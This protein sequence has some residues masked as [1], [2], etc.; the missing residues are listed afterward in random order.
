MR[1]LAL[2]SLAVLALGVAASLRHVVEPAASLALPQVPLPPLFLSP[3]LQCIILLFIL[4]YSM[5]L[6]L[7]PPS[8]VLGLDLVLIDFSL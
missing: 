3:L 4:L 5:L 2:L 8:L 7:C 1:F 6:R